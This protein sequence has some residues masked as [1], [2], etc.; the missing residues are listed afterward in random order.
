MV[1]LADERLSSTDQR[2]LSHLHQRL[3]SDPKH[4]DSWRLVAKIY[5]HAELEKEAI[6][7]A[8]EDTEDR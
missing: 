1:L 4:A 5:H 6:E 8:R 7:A 2:I 3:D